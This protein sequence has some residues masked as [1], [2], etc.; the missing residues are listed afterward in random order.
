MSFV[1]ARFTNEESNDERGIPPGCLV[2]GG[3][4]G[5][6]TLYHRTRADI[7]ATVSNLGILS[8]WETVDRGSIVVRRH[9]ATMA[10]SRLSRNFVEK[11]KLGET[12]TPFSFQD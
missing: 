1:C 7:A 5:T 11:N 8:T 6:Q 9:S 12:P 10:S 4:R 3:G 2:W